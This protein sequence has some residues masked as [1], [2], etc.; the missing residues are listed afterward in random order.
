MLEFDQYYYVNMPQSPIV[1]KEQLE[2]IVNLYEVTP[3]LVQETQSPPNLTQETTRLHN[4]LSLLHLPIRRT[5]GK[6]PLIDYSHSH[7][8]T[9]VEYLNIL[10][11]ETMDKTTA[12]EI[13]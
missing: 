11:K 5:R 8:V 1:I 3:E 4:L 2:E 9:F 13:K 12:E 10:R 6:E 7:V